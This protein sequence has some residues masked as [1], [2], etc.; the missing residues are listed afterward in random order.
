MPSHLH[1]CTLAIFFSP[2]CL[3]PHLLGKHLCTLEGLAQISA[4]G[5]VPLA[6]CVVD[7][8][9]DKVFLNLYMAFPQDWH[10]ADTSTFAE[11]VCGIV[12]VFQIIPAI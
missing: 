4:V 8:R 5:S 3:L 12:L 2:E 9:L 10:I 1:A 6:L 11:C 7:S